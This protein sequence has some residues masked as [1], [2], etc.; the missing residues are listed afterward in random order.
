[1]IVADTD[2]LIDFLAGHEPAA[3]RV[4]LEIERAQ[5]RTTAV[6]R[7]ELLVGA[8]TNRQL[9][10]IQLLLG[11]IPTLPLDEPA[12]DRAAEVKRHLDRQGVSIG[13]A[14]ALIAGI[15]LAHDAILLTRNARHFGRVPGLVLSMM[16]DER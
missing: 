9:R 13:M 14:D 15:V 11:A 8:R 2:V 6:T 16:A 3:G 4:A 5:L 12:A 7:V 10:D 1:M